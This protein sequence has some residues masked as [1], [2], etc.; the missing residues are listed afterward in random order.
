MNKFLT[1]A[2]ILLFAVAG[3]FY[4]SAPQDSFDEP[5][6]GDEYLLDDSYFYEDELSNSGGWEDYGYVDFVESAEDCTQY[7]QYD[8]EEGY[9]Y[10]ECEDEEDCQ[11][12]EALIEEEL[13][14][15]AEEY[16]S[17]AGNFHEFEGDAE[18]LDTEVVYELSQGEQFNVVSGTET[19][20]HLKIRRWLASISPD[21]FSDTY[22]KEFGIFNAPE[23]GDGAFVEPALDGSGKWNMYV[24]RDVMKDSEREM[25][26]T[27]IHEF[28]HILTLNSSQV[29]E[30]IAEG[31]CTTHYIDEGCPRTGSYFQNFFQ[32]FWFNGSGGYDAY[33]FVTEYAATN[34]GEDIAES[35][36][37]F[38][39]QNKTAD[40]TIAEQKTNFFY[41]YPELVRMRSLMRNALTPFVRAQLR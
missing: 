32:E 9:C 2:I 14:G 25:V 27:L 16:E 35:F 30:T 31:A 26:F 28:A 11:E 6:V 17:F 20:E 1:V 13:A 12:I 21:K 5:L 4:F 41:D 33:Y 23:S 36:A 24:N 19:D 15:L 18:D 37:A 3:F 22:I 39:L 8:A 29:D 40:S 10:Y 38:V 7:E 34:P